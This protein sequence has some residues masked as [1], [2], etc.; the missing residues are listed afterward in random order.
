MTTP[1]P[2]DVAARLFPAAEIAGLADHE[3][4]RK[5]VVHKLGDAHARQDDAFV[6]GAFR[7]MA[8]GL[9]DGSTPTAPASK[10]APAGS[11]FAGMRLTDAQRAESESGLA[12]A[13]ENVRAR[14]GAVT[15][16][17]VRDTA[18]AGASGDGYRDT[19]AQRAGT[20][21]PS[22]VAVAEA[23]RHPAAPRFSDNDRDD[24]YADTF[25]LRAAG[26]SR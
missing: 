2:R 11:P 22:A 15:G 8:P 18:T 17:A 19:F 23:W 3:L 25:A 1:T 20:A 4:R 5:V 14:G 21:A 26:G 10:A 6:E 7:Y 9:M 12:A 13:L 16:A 24:G